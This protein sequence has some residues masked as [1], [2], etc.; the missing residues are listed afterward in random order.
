MD[1]KN[2]E[3]M[4][5]EDEVQRL[6]K[7]LVGKEEEY[8]KQMKRREKEVEEEVKGLK[9]EIKELKNSLQERNTVIK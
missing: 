2:G 7:A 6:R 1:F 3:L 5:L 4:L 9:N 8:K